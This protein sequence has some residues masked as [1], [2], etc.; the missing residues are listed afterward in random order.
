[1]LSDGAAISARDEALASLTATKSISY[2]NLVAVFDDFIQTVAQFHTDV[3]TVEQNLIAISQNLTEA[4]TNINDLSTEA[5][6][7]ILAYVDGI[8]TLVTMFLE[9]A[10]GT[11]LKESL[12]C[13]N[14]YSIYDDV[15]SLVCVDIISVFNVLW[16]SIGWCAGILPFAIVSWALLIKYFRGEQASSPEIVAWSRQGTRHGANTGQTMNTRG[17]YAYSDQ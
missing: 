5:E 17:G 16:F 10:L 8:N 11:D 6:T 7:D 15:F 13:R 2:T 12:R 4:Q 14:I 3:D 1:M 9:N